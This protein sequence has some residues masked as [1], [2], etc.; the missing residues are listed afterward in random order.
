MAALNKTGDLLHTEEMLFPTKE[1]PPVKG[2]R[3]S[4]N[5]L[6]HVV[7]AAGDERISRHG[8]G[9]GVIEAVR[10]SPGIEDILPAKFTTLCVV[11]TDHPV[12]A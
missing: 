5:L 7:L 11:H 6:T 2:N 9:E 12:I 3:R 8:D 1:K 10:V 4:Q